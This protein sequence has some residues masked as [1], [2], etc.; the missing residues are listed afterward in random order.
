MAHARRKA[1]KAGLTDLDN[2][3]S[4]L[5]TELSTVERANEKSVD[6]PAEIF[7]KL[8][9]AIISYRLGGTDQRI[10]SSLGHAVGKWI[11]IADALDD[12]K[13][14]AKKDRYNPFLNLYDGKLPTKEDYENI[15]LAL[16]NELYE[17]EAALDLLEFD[18]DAIEQIVSNILYLGLPERIRGISA[19]NQKEKNCKHSKER[20]DNHQ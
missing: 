20:T 14:D 3:I 8:L 5:L 13:E 16:K 1:L 7:G 17:A 19:E 18:N 6:A 4:Q 2:T 15:G 11:Y 9:S 10:A 12:W